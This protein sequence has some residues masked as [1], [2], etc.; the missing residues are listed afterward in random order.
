MIFIR[1]TDNTSLYEDLFMKVK[2]TLSLLGLKWGTLQSVTDGAKKL[3]CRKTGAA[4]RIISEVM[5]ETSVPS[6]MFHCI[7][8]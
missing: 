2:E 8:H 3:C 5:Q 1:G 6:M 7:I 4:G